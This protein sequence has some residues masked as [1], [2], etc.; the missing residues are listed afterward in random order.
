MGACPGRAGRFGCRGRHRRR[1]RSGVRVGGGRNVAPGDEAAVNVA[2]EGKVGE[3]DRLGGGAV[4]KRCRVEGG[5]PHLVADVVQADLPADHVFDVLD[6][7]VGEV[8]VRTATRGSG[9]EAVVDGADRHG[10]RKGPPIS[11][12]V[13]SQ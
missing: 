2:I 5:G 1:K 12:P 7:E 8:L 6:D 13:P 9:G 11:V 3:A 10:V 4:G